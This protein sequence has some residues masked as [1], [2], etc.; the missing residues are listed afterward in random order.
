MDYRTNFGDDL[1][2][3]IPNSS[4]NNNRLVVPPPIPVDSAATGPLNTNTGSSSNSRASILNNNLRG[5]W[6]RVEPKN[7]NPDTLP[8]QR[9]LHAGAV[10]NHQLIIFGGDLNVINPLSG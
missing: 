7:K 2:L 6:E 3:P 4:N 1:P 8:C 10:W 5:Y 9:S